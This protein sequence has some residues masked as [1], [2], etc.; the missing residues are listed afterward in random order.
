MQV[1]LDNMYGKL[2]VSIL[3]TVCCASWTSHELWFTVWRNN[4]TVMALCFWHK[5]HENVWVRTTYWKW[6][7]KTNH[8]LHFTWYLLVFP[9]FDIIWLQQFSFFWLCGRTWYSKN[10]FKKNC[11]CQFVLT[12]D[13][14][15]VSRCMS[16]KK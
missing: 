14:F 4:S 10:I 1:R 11:L 7:W 16:C 13:N 15:P 2:L 6:R 5:V 3:D 9:R 12:M 8:K